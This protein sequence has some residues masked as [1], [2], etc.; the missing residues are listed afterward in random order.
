MPLKSSISKIKN[1]IKNFMKR[2]KNRQDDIVEVNLPGLSIKLNR[3]LDIDT[4]HEVTVV[5]PRA[6]IRKRCLDGAC[7]RYEYEIIYSSITVVH[8]PR[9]PLAGPPPSPP[10]EIPPRKS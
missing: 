3:K 2:K 9:H 10:P 6:E 4:P 8:A 7:T 1:W 5:V